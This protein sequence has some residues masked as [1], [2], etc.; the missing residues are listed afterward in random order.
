M[1]ATHSRRDFLL[2]SAAGLALPA[3]ASA[4]DPK[5][6]KPISVVVWDERQPEQRQ[7]YDDFLG[8]Q[9][10]GHLKTRPGLGVDP[11]PAMRYG[12]ESESR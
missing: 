9:I 3:A 6:A 10:A 4:A 12:K 5:K 11:E 8:N 1:T 2:A 7:A